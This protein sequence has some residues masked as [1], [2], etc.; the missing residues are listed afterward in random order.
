MLGWK[1]V[2]LQFVIQIKHIMK[3][4]VFFSLLISL[5]ILTQAQDITFKYLGQTLNNGDTV[6]LVAD[7]DEVKFAPT[8]YNAGMERHV[9]RIHVTTLNETNIVPASVCAGGLCVSG[10]VSNH[11]A[12]GPHATVSDAYIDFM[13]PEQPTD[14]L[15][16]VS[17]IDTLDESNQGEVYVKITSNTEGISGAW[18]QSEVRMYPNPASEMLSIECPAEAT[19]IALYDMSGKS[20]RTMAAAEGAL[21]MDLSGLRKG[22]YM[23]GIYDGQGNARVQKVVKR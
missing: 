13:V 3:K 1:G 15:F 6:T 5:A 4:A 7:G 8:L 23:V 2:I 10:T 21:H 9:V 16:K 14:G 12:I 18:A 19:H 17:A 20:V 22:V 11:F